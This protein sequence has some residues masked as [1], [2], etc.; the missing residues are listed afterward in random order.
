MFNRIHQA[1]TSAKTW[2]AAQLANLTGLPVVVRQPTRRERIGQGIR[3]VAMRTWQMLGS[4]S[5]DIVFTNF[6]K[7]SAMGAYL[8]ALKTLGGVQYPSPLIAYISVP[9][10]LV[11]LI[12]ADILMKNYVL[13]E[14]ERIQ[15]TKEIVAQ[16]TNNAPGN[17]LSLPMHSMYRRLLRSNQ[18]PTW[19]ELVN[20]P[21]VLAAIAESLDG[22]SRREKC[23]RVFHTGLAAAYSAIGYSGAVFVYF[24]LRESLLLNKHNETISLTGIGLGSSVGIVAAL[25]TIRDLNGEHA[26][27]N[28]RRAELDQ[29]IN[30]LCH[31]LNGLP[32]THY[33]PDLQVLLTDWTLDN[34]ASAHMDNN[35]H[36]ISVRNENSYTR[37]HCHRMC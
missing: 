18:Q 27:L 29:A 36:A 37:P 25:K 30:L 10:G 21:I 3:Y 31:K 32:T 17:L 20:H 28:A 15:D 22:V 19:L 24:I 13:K 4:H 1:L 8:L 33:H 16:L 5:L 26:D 12:T 23:L 6:L 34:A 7:A 14:K 9:T 35:Q 11:I 2:A